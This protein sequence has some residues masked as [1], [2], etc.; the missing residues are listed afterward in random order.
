VAAAHVKTPTTLER[1]ERGRLVAVT[2]ERSL[3]VVAVPQQTLAL[4]AVV[5]GGT[6]TAVA[7]VPEVLV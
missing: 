5:S 2:G 6:A 7:A 1:R 4:V 3:V